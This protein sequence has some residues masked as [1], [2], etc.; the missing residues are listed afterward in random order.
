MVGIVDRLIQ[1]TRAY[2]YDL[3]EK[4]FSGMSTDSSWKA[5][6][7]DPASS[8]TAHEPPPF[9]PQAGKRSGLPHSEALARCYASFDLPFGAPIAQVT[10]RW[11]AYLRKCHPDLHTADATKQAQATELTQQLNRDYD[12]IKAAWKQYQR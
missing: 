10:K 5:A 11:K 2:V 12:K 4:H 3:V 6:S 8:S 1:N 9:E 7:E